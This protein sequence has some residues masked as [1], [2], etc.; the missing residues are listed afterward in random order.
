MISKAAESS[1]IIRIEVWPKSVAQWKKSVIFNS[2]VAVTALK[3]GLK[4]S[5]KFDVNM[6]RI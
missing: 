3:N 6:F 1:S 5:S 4:L 2:F